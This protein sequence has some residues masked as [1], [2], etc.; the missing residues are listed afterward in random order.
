VTPTPGRG[1]NEDDVDDDGGD[2][3]GSGV[4]DDGDGGGGDRAAT[5]TVVKFVL[6]RPLTPEWDRMPTKK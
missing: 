4:R 1:H 2:D 6:A 3:R 5:A